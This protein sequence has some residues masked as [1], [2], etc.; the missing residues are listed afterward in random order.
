MAVESD[1]T[2]AIEATVSADLAVHT[3]LAGTEPPYVER[4]AHGGA[5]PDL[6]GM[7]VNLYLAPTAPTP[8]LVA[9]AGLLRAA[10]AQHQPR[11]RW[12]RAGLRQAQPVVSTIF[13]VARRL[14]IASSAS[15]RRSK[16]ISALTCG[17]RRPA[18]QLS[19]S[20]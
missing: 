12:R 20:A 5:L 17:A 15:G 2:R 10:W 6:P 7:K 4:I 8:A 11:A 18:R 3:V 16:G 14:R 1:S 9:L 13:P 19:I